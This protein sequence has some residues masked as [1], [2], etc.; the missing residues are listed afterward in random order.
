MPEY[1]KAH[2]VALASALLTAWNAGK[3]LVEETPTSADE[4]PPKGVSRVAKTML[5]QELYKTWRTGHAFKDGPGL[6]LWE[7]LYPET[8]TIW[9]VCAESA[10]QFMER[11]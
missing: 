5:A 2:L 9:R 7:D 4:T 3:K 6:P 1:N 10:F 11:A 8:Q